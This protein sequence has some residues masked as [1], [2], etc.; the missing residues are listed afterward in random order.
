MK[1]NK[2]LALLLC[3]SMTSVCVMPVCAAN[4][5]ALENESETHL[6]HT[7]IPSIRPIKDSSASDLN[8]TLR[9]PS[10]FWDNCFKNSITIATNTLGLPAPTITEAKY[11]HAKLYS[12]ARLKINWT[13]VED[14]ESYE[15][16]I[17]KADGKVINYTTE[18]P[19]IFDKESECLKVYIEKTHTLTA[20]TVQVRAVSGDTA[21]AWSEPKKISCNSLH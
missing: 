2:L 15:V 10:S 17:T 1:L 4:T 20:A 16:R 19:E 11:I 13:T 9:L 8:I 3:F 14:A 5:V 6:T 21:G 12:P 18:E 7:L